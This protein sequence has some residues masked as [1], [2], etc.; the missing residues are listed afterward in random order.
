MEFCSGNRKTLRVLSS[1]IIQL[2]RTQ[3]TAL[4]TVICRRSG[5]LPADHQHSS[6]TQL[7]QPDCAA[8]VPQISDHQP[9][10]QSL[11]LFP[12][13]WQTDTNQKKELTPVSILLEEN[14]S[15]QHV[16]MSS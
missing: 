14:N 7:S 9:S 6:K 4:R 16:E 8:L 11:A 5:K 1:N 13:D 12:A 3:D 15:Q 10:R 2:H